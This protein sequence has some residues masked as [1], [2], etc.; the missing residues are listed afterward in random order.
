MHGDGTP[1]PGDL[2]RRIAARRHYLGWSRGQLA[3]R[4]G[5]SESYLTHIETHPAVVTMA[6]LGGLADAL[7]TTVEALLG[8]GPPTRTGRRPRRPR[9]APGSP[10]CERDCPASDRCRPSLRHG[11]GRR[12]EGSGGREG[13]EA[14]SRRDEKAHHADLTGPPDIPG[15]RWRWPAGTRLMSA[16]EPMKPGGTGRAAAVTGPVSAGP[17]Q[18]ARRS[19]PGRAFSPGDRA[20]IGQCCD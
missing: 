13:A 5:L 9:Q 19:R 3:V 20:V 18:Q 1:G 10:M 8:A 15:P 16:G 12:P 11:S 14:H 17:C 4:A 6:S 2:G 7:G